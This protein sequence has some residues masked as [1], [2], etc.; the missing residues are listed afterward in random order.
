MILLVVEK[1]KERLFFLNGNLP[2]TLPILSTK[3]P[4]SLI[5][6][7]ISLSLLH[8]LPPHPKTDPPNPQPGPYD[9]LLLVPGVF[10]VPTKP[11]PRR[12]I[13]RIYVSQ[14]E[15]CYNGR[16]NWNIP[17]H[18]AR[19]TFSSPA[20]TPGPLTLAVY[21]PD[22]SAKT[23]FFSATLTP[24]RW[25]PAIPVSTRFLPLSTTLA[26]PPVPATAPLLAA[27]SSGRDGDE[28][29]GSDAAT[30]A[31]VDATADPPTDPAL[32]CGTQHWRSMPINTYSPATRGMWVTVHAPG[33]GPYAAGAGKPSGARPSEAETAEAV[34]EA[35]R[36][37]PVAARP[38]PVGV[39][40][41]GAEMEIL[42]PVEWKL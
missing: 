18:L 16:H 25:L 6:P 34:A 15:T 31:V 12:R 21:A 40:M 1:Q 37:W 39:W 2:K 35:T 13:T 9:E 14:R 20:G 27:G 17:K 19:F 30:D 5:Q 41:D 8:P 36:W 11:T 38:W 33:T 28:D 32:L 29:G 3:F 26:Q 4:T 24:F 23:P 22:P 7:T 42:A 10:R